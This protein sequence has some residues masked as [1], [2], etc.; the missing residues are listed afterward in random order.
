MMPLQLDHDANAIYG[1]YGAEIDETF[2]R[3]LGEA[4]GTRLARGRLVVGGDV[5][6]STLPL[7]HALI[8]GV[9][10]TGCEVFDVG[11]LP[12]PVLYFAKDRLWAD[13]SVMVTA[14]HRSAEQNGFKITFG[15]FPANDVDLS[16]L[17]Q[18]VQNEGPF[19][20]GAGTLYEQDMI[21]PYQSFLI[22][23][24]VPTDPLRV[25][26]DANNGSM[27]HVAPPTLDALGYDLVAC[28]CSAQ[29]GFGDRIPDP[30]WH[31]NRAR[32]SRNV[33]TNQAH[34]GVAYDGD[35]DRVLFADEQGTV[36]TPEQ[37][38]VLF[39][40]SLLLYQSGSEIVYDGAFAP[41]VNREILKVGGRPV[42]LEAGSAEIKRTVLQRGA[43]LGADRNGHYYFRAMGGED[44]L[45]ATLV[46]LRIVSRYDAALETLLA[47]LE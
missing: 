44:A 39:A 30:F 29:A 38:L 28:N 32:L 9:L 31:D 36:L 41:Y 20:S 5:R 4:I 19:A 16:E 18:I 21:E 15:K 37:T 7:K 12:T 46:M 23:R 27:S 6:P 24:F 43:V 26:V 34:L 14:S 25:I 35:G 1:A 13:G 11:I 42:P 33:L 2:A 17:W 45:Y 22:A 3:L 10:R 8:E 40:R 47:D